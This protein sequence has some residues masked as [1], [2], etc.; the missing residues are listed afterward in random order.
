MAITK[1]VIE[2]GCIVCDACQDVCPDVFKVGDDSCEVL[3]VDF[4]D[5]EDEIEEAAESCPV[6]VIKFS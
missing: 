1:V 2:D 4:E 6:E 3:N 5:F